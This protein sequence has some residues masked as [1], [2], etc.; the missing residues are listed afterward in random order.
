M[1]NVLTKQA[2]LQARDEEIE[3]VE[4]PE[5]GGA[6]FVRSIAA[7]GRGQIEAAAAR[8]KDSKGKDESFARTFTVRLVALSLCDERG[9]RLFSDGEIS[10]L[11]KKNGRVISRI[12][13]VSQRLSGFTKQDLEEMEKNSESVQAEG[14]PSA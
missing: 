4:V 7:S 12:A 1:S 8:Y 11:Q 5:W 9:E 2:I 3:R 10:E 14:S 13:E 6:V